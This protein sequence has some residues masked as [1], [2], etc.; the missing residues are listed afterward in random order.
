MTNTAL[1]TALAHHRAWTTGNLE[2]ALSYLAPDVVLD[3][4]AGRIEGI[5]G[6]RGFLAPFAE[7]FLIRAELI[8]AF[9]DDSSAIVMYDTETIPAK[10]APAAE[11]V[12]VKDGLIVY[13]RFVF[14]RTPFTEFRSRQ[15]E[16][17][18]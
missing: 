6:Y 17:E 9:G 16:A 12:Q 5:D 2:L 11:Y 3:A 4:P 10:S 8:A 14:D 18:E 13:N 1:Q 7:T 15:A